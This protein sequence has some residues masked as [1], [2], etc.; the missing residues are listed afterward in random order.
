MR[1]IAVVVMLG[2]ILVGGMLLVLFF[3][4]YQRPFLEIVNLNTRLHNQTRL[5]GWLRTRWKIN[6]CVIKRQQEQEC[7]RRSWENKH[8]CKITF[9]RYGW[10]EKSILVCSLYGGPGRWTDYKGKHNVA[11]QEKSWTEVASGGS[12]VRTLDNNLLATEVARKLNKELTER[13]RAI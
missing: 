12:K 3:H 13:K 1:S 7:F 2:K 6:D 5:Q 9:W 4:G 8:R 11:Q 10:Y